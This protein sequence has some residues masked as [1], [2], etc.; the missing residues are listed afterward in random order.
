MRPLLVTCVSLIALVS[1]ACGEDQPAAPS[2]HGQEFPAAV[3]PHIQ[4]EHGKRF[5]VV[6]AENASVGD[7]W[8]LKTPPDATIA[9]AEQDDYVSDSPS[10]TVGGGGKRYFV[11]TAH[12]PGE[13]ALELYNCFRGCKSADDIARSKTYEIHLSV[14]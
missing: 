13:S 3:N 14:T 11:F 8:Q 9:T 10:G 4:I 2:G 5:S 12:Q 6:V 7:S 1:T